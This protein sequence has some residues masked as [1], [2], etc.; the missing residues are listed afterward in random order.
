MAAP[1]TERTKE[2]QRRVI[3]LLLSGGV[4]TSDSTDEWQF[5]MIITVRL[6]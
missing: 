1:L 4:T 6:K 5:S 2:Q 3:R